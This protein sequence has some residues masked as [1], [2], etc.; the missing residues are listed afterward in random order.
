MGCVSNK[1]EKEILEW[2]ETLEEQL[3][4]TC[5]RKQNFDPTNLA[6]KNGRTIK[7][8]EE[9]YVIASRKILY[10]KWSEA[11]QSIDGKIHTV[12]NVDNLSQVTFQ[13]VD[14]I[15]DYD[16]NSLRF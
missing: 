7:Y 4:K 12:R 10:P 3:E 15:V 1:E 14:F 9:K 6:V 5:Q 13:G 2:V 11:A 8:R 16:P